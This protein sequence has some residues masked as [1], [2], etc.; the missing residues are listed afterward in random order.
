MGSSI[1]THVMTISSKH[2]SKDADALEAVF[3]PTEFT[4]EDEQNQSIALMGKDLCTFII[5]QSDLPPM[6]QVMVVSGNTLT[7]RS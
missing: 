6:R 3:A 1:N 4:R 7:S 2:V 5:I